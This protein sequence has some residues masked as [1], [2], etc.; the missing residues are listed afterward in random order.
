[1]HWVISYLPLYR[2]WK[3]EGLVNTNRNRGEKKHI[4]PRIC[5]QQ[6]AQRQASALVIVFKHFI[7]SVC[8]VHFCQCW[9]SV[10]C[11]YSMTTSGDDR[12][13]VQVDLVA[14][15]SL[16]LLFSFQLFRNTL[17]TPPFGNHFPLLSDNTVMFLPYACIN[18]HFNSLPV[19]HHSWSKPDI[20]YKDEIL[21]D[22]F[23]QQWTTE[24]NHHLFLTIYLAYCYLI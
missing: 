10:V 21:Y 22:G 6:R 3:Q 15:G 2:V 1:M 16:L 24:Y 12:F 7:N 13:A 4:L 11:Y 5:L 17:D 8:T 19:P 18:H 14:H 23:S 9:L 20:G